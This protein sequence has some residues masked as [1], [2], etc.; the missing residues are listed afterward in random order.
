MDADT[1]G[2]YAMAPRLFA[3]ARGEYAW[4]AGREA[5][6]AGAAVGGLSGQWWA[7]HALPKFGA[8]PL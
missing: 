7:L 3:S 6:L 8:S 5:E 2:G 4:G 1:P